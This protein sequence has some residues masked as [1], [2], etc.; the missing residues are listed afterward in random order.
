MNMEIVQRIVDSPVLVS[1]VVFVVV[2][3]PNERYTI[4]ELSLESL[5]SLQ[6]ESLSLQLESLELRLE[7]LSLQLESLQLRLESLDLSLQ[8]E[9]IGLE[10][11]DLNLQLEN[12]ERILFGH[13]AYFELLEMIENVLSTHPIHLC[14]PVSPL[15]LF[16]Y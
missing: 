3:V 8:L 1:W 5:I 9:V 10:S 14:N 15:K 4:L 6:L 2:V 11:L 7:S 13:L 12:L 16:Q